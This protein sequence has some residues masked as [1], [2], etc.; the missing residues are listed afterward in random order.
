MFLTLKDCS[1]GEISQQSWYW[2]ANHRLIN[3]GDINQTVTLGWWLELNREESESSHP[4]H[5]VS[6]CSPAGCID[7]CC[8]CGGRTRCWTSAQGRSHNHGNPRS[9]RR[10]PS[11]P[12]A[13]QPP[14]EKTKCCFL[15][16]KTSQ[17]GR[18]YCSL[19]QWFLNFFSPWP[20][21]E[22]WCLLGTQTSENSRSTSSEIL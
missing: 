18:R 2:I 14:E 11:C 7:G 8:L 5:C 3:N 21:I 6:T 10:P 16:D 22:T 17:W 1:F 19:D 4:Y 15:N 20:K 12:R 9:H 13:H